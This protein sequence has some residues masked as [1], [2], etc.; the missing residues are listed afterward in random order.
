MEQSL[1]KDE[2]QDFSWLSSLFLRVWILR[3]AVDARY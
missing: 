2:S 3:L 1:K